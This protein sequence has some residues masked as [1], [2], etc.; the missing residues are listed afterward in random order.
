[1]DGNPVRIAIVGIG[2][3]CKALAT[4]IQ[5]SGAFQIVTCFTRTQAKRDEFA[6]TFRCD[7]E[8]SY[9][10]VLRREDVEAILLTTPNSAHTEM[11][12]LAA[13]HGKHVLVEKPIANRVS[14]ARRMVEACRK[15]GVVL[16]VAHNQRRLSGY[17]K[18]KAMIQAGSLGKIITVETNFSHNGGFRLTPK[19]WRWYEEECPGG[20]MMT[21]G[22]HPAD[23]L[24]YLLGPVRSVSA[25]FNRLCLQTEIIDTGTAILQFESGALGYLACNFVTPWVNY[26]NVYGTEANLYLTVE[27]PARKADETPGQYG[28]YWNYAGRNS[29]LYLK[30]KGEDQKVKID[31]EPGEILTEEVKEFADCIRNHKAPETSGPEGIQALAVILAAIRSARSSEI[32]NLAK[33]L[34]E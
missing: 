10:D 27:L 24:Q 1:M 30:R 28:D 20:P 34:A 22:V 2:M 5:K 25:F 17:R 4:V 32:V 3:W 29:A 11:A 15:N 16:S 14:D 19:M 21:L 18:M 9:E 33:V 12:V 7:Q 31:L 26:C 13:D 6:A 8:T 23:T